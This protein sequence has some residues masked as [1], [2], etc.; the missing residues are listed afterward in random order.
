MTEFLRKLGS[1]GMGLMNLADMT[2][3]YRKG[4]ALMK[5]EMALRQ[6]V[7]TI[8]ELVPLNQENTTRGAW[9]VLTRKSFFVMVNEKTTRV[10]IY[11][12]W[13]N[14]IMDTNGPIEFVITDLKDKTD[15]GYERIIKS[16]TA[17][18]RLV[19]K[20]L[21]PEDTPDVRHVDP[22]GNAYSESTIPDIAVKSMYPEPIEPSEMSGREYFT[23]LASTIISNPPTTSDRERIL[24]GVKLTDGAT[25]AMLDHVKLIANSSLV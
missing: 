14:I 7:R 10:T 12:A 17:V 2:Y 21:N 24:R 22:F 20:V 11:D 25:S 16:P 6:N 9:L 1:A 23:V 19:F 13:N 5:T 18:A 8:G 4:M 15:V 3:A